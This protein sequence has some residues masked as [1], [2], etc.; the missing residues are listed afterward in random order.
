MSIP[1]LCFW[2]YLQGCLLA[3]G[4]LAIGIIKVDPEDDDRSIGVAEAVI[5]WP[6]FVLAWILRGGRG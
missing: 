4:A 5:L 1:D 3:A 2:I 6:M